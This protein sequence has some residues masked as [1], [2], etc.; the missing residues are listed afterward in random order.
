VW[1]ASTLLSRHGQAYGPDI[2][3]ALEALRIGSTR[4]SLN[5]LRWRIRSKSGI[6]EVIYYLQKGTHQ[7][8]FPF[9]RLQTS[10]VNPQPTT[11]SLPSAR[12]Q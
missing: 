7:T 8:V 10:T 1:I 12:L 6:E 2:A 4:R 9:E 11:K 5:D 3:L